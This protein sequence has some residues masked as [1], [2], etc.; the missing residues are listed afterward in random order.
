[1]T[2]VA[3]A[4]RRLQDSFAA[5]RVEAIAF[6]LIVLA[7]AVAVALSLIPTRDADAA[8]ITIPI[9]QAKA[10]QLI[11]A[12]TGAAANQVRAVGDQAKLINAALPFAGGPVHAA[13]PFAVSGSDVDQRR[14]LLCMTQAVYYE[15]GFEPAE[16]R[17]AVAQVILN[18]MRHPAFPKS[19]CGVVYQG[20]GSGVCQ[21]TFV[22]DGALYRAPARD[23]WVEAERIAR[24]ALGG[25]VEKRVGEAT[26]YHADYVA[27][28][29]APMLAKV[30]QIGQHIFYRWPGAWGMPAAFNGRYIGEPRDP[31]S[32]R[33]P[34]PSNP[35]LANAV[36]VVAGPITDGTVLKRAPNDVGGLLDTSKGWT[37]SIPGPDDSEG[38]S[39]KLIA[40]Q[41]KKPAEP[42]PAAVAAAG[43][44]QVASR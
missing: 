20:A 44:T 26:H 34:P 17:R 33:P 10:E 16:G 32:M 12:T 9:T 41:Q 22:C 39:Q 3:L 38:V 5:L 2:A 4:S 8:T 35:T 11:N 27:P 7:A 23:A 24:A 14:A 6:G 15:A 30:A 18:R 29:W 25:Y 42:A 43:S 28:R 13:S 37:L 21:F 19:V 31:L 40:S 36:A 1:M